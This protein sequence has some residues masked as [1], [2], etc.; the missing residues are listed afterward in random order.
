VPLHDAGAQQA[1]IGQIA[2]GAVAAQRRYGVPAAVTIA[3]A[4]DE[5]GWGRSSLATQDHNL[6][7]IKGTGPAGRDP[8]PTREYNNGKAV[9][10]T[11]S[12]RV[13]HN[14]AESIDDHGKLLATSQYYRQAMADRQDPNAFAAALT[15][16]YATDPD[17]GAKLIGLMRRY[18]LYRYDIGAPAGPSQAA[19]PGRTTVPRPRHTAPATP[20]S[21]SPPA[22]PAPT[23]PAPA[24]PSHTPPSPT[25]PA[26]SPPAPSPSQTPGQGRSA[27]YR[28]RSDAMPSAQ[29][30]AARRLPAPA[31]I[32][33]ARIASR[34][35]RA[36]TSRY[37]NCIPASVSNAF[38]T[39][40]KVPLIRAEPLY[41]DVAGL[42][43]IRWELLAACDWMQCQAQPRYSPVHGEK[44]GA[45]NPDGTIY[46][47][48]SAALR[49]CAE[50]LVTLARAV[51]G[52]D[53]TTQGD[54]SV[55]DLANV[56]AAFRWGGLLRLH[57]TSAMEFPYSVAGLTVQHI[58]MRWPNIA[59][60]NTPDKPG[61]RF[62]MPFGA[63]PIV[64]GL[65]Y[66]ATV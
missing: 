42:S 43:G 40:A 39:M 12:F 35:A 9:T 65:N 37:Q 26:P 66:P 44:L 48:K 32:R 10:R 25:P 5:S 7:G 23:S 20:A 61:R 31:S 49:Q 2:P 38:L 34:N 36:R 28:P 16:V 3:Q 41:R 56:F 53:L 46:R 8:Q 55:R 4:I 57:H 62:R 47:T 58:N 33:P 1:F 19:T 27:A 52:I 51:Y 18:D 14:A 17:Y 24:P 50:D 21:T 22:P 11:A 59:D 13:Y 63:V 60:P 15:G 54:L 6:F 30:V 64:L 45:L 29:T